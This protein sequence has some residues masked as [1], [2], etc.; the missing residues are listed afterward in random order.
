[1]FDELHSALIIF[2]GKLCDDDCVTILDNNEINII[3]GKTHIL[4]GHRNNKDGLWGIPISRPVRHSSHAII[5]KNKTKTELIQYLHGCCFIPTPRTVLKAI[6][7]GN[8]LTWPGPNSQQLLKNLPH[9]I[10]T[11]I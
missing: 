6:R 8:L 9:S 11:T 7:N 1:M 3:K 10:T 5:T 4:R 2:L